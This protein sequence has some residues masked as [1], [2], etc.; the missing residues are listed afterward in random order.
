MSTGL[1]TKDETFRDNY[2]EFAKFFFLAFRVPCSPK[3]A[4]FGAYHLVNHQ[5]TELNA[6]TTNQASNRHSLGSSFQSHCLWETL[7][8]YT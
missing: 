4:Y 2:I 7:Y 5:Y 3:L 1:P 8:I 6:E